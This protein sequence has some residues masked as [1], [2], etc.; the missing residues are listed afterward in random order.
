MARA[1]RVAKQKGI[2]LSVV[3]LPQGAD[4]ADL[5]KAQ[6]PDALISLIEG[7]ISVPE[8]EV[9]KILAEAD[10]DT[11]GG[12]DR[13]LSAVLP[14]I[15]TV[16]ANT[17]TWDHLMSY[18]ADRLSVT[19]QDLT[20]QISA[21]RPARPSFRHDPGEAVGI[22]QSSRLPIHRGRVQHGKGL[23]GDVPG[24]G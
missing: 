17:A 4:P 3:P 2:E 7:A 24:A 21:P 10:L 23:F 1:A 11:P 5:V 9:R 19:P 6:G 16:P 18:T 22:P 15:G 12:R 20:A 8:F 14:V 13:A